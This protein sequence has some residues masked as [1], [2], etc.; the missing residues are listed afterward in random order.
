LDCE[1]I[2]GSLSISEPKSE[3]LKTFLEQFPNF[4]PFP[5]KL[6]SNVQ[7]CVQVQPA[8]P[9]KGGALPNTETFWSPTEK[10]KPTA[11]PLVR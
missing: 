9:L 10:F 1:L 4:R 3:V 6:P 7:V 5:H 8:K 2:I 11:E